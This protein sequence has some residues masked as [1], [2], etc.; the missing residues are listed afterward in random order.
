M[1]KL[2]LITL[3]LSGLICN[4]FAITTDESGTEYNVDKN[5]HGAVLKSKQATLYLGKDCDAFSPQYGKGSWK[6]A[7]TDTWVNLEKKE[8]KFLHQTD[9]S[10]NDSKC[11]VTDNKSENQAAKKEEPATKME[12]QSDMKVVVTKYNLLIK[13]ES[14]FMWELH[15]K[16]F[17][18]NIGSKDAKNV[19]VGF[20]CHDC[21]KENE[22]IAGKWVPIKEGH[23]LRED[24]I[25][26]LP[27]GGKEEFNFQIGLTVSD[28]KP[29]YSPKVDITIISL[30]KA[31]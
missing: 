1:K 4:S 15:A 13:P 5:R 3:L 26:Y 22:K 16:G 30:G 24:R 19:V 14:K 6:W 17:V 8:F 29:N 10:H 11:K 28:G 21:A 23:P 31:N 7:N 2:I 9:L 25:A 18:Q 20:V 27:A 12:I